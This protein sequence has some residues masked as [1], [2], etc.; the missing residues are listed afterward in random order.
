MMTITT[1]A[2]S[3]TNYASSAKWS[4]NISVTV[5][6]G[7]LS[8]FDEFCEGHTAVAPIGLIGIDKYVNPWLGVGVEARGLVGTGNGKYNTRTMIDWVNVSAYTKLNVLNAFNY[9]G[10]R[11]VF[12]PVLYVGAGWGHA[13]AGNHGAVPGA[14]HVNNMTYRAGLELNYN[15]DKE[16][17]WAV[18][19]NP[20][21]V[22]G[23]IDNGRL[24][25]H[26]GNFEL[27]AGVVYRFKTSNGTRSI[28]KAKLYDADEVAALTARITELECMKSAA[29][30]TTE[31]VKE[32]TVTKIVPGKFVTTFEF[33]KAEL[34]DEA[35]AELDKIEQGAKVD[36]D[37]YAS[38]EG[39]EK[40]NLGLSERRMKAVQEYLS[41]R[42]V[43]F[44]NVNFHGAP[45]K[46]SNRIV[47]VQRV[48]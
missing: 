4:D 2:Q 11:K 24:N 20:S 34:S 31:V 9:T 30:N 6:G 45:N 19:V 26:A 38:P 43:N 5:Q 13:T 18:V 33:N 32:V 46:Y 29:P 35:K 36:I 47:V 25:K 12:E 48:N 1:S 41:G 42:G 23:G 3:Q 39:N 44:N 16:K 14:H 21:V 40:Y 28:A 22:W 7:A 27:T 8:S 15:L 10:V 37:A 17:A